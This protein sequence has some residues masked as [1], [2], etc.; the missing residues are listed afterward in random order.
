MPRRPQLW[1]PYAVDVLAQRRGGVVTRSELLQLGMTPSAVAQRTRREGAW[2][3]LL[4][5]TY[6]THRAAPN[7]RERLHAALA[8]AGDGATLTGLHALALH[9][10][11]AVSAS[12]PAHVLVPYQRRR[13]DHPLVTVERTRRLPAV[14]RLDGMPCACLP[15]AVVDACRRLDDARQVQAVVAE[16]VQR[17]RC[18]VDALVTEVREGPI[19]HSALVR[20]AVQHVV[21]GVRSVAEADGRALVRN[22][23]LPEPLWNVDVTTAAG[24]FLARPDGWWPERAVAWQID[25][26][27]YHLDPESW[28][29]TLR[30]HAALAARGVLVL[31]TLPSEIRQCPERVVAEL[32]G[33]L[34]A[35]AGR[36]APALLWRPSV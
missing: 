22:A 35:G 13:N 30:R 20:A 19:R 21:A 9:G 28:A 7:R 14:V 18:S 29:L 36:P 15:R 26:R 32:R 17:R 24:E 12:G 5:G 3:S 10:L 34:A 6:L 8:Y 31:H 27:E 4:P 2:Q 23:G 33:I 25:S 16:A 1:D 11:S